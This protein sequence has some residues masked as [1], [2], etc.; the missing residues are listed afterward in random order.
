MNAKNA[1]RP[2]MRGPRPR[3]DRSDVDTTYALVLIIIAIMLAD[4]LAG[5]VTGGS[6]HPWGLL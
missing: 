2:T 3:A 5:I 4:V 1:P 6:P